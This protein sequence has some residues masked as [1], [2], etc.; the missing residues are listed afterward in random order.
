MKIHFVYDTV[1]LVKEKKSAPAGDGHIFTEE[2]E[3]SLCGKSHSE[4]GAKVAVRQNRIEGLMVCAACSEAWK[5]HP[6]SPWKKF[7]AAEA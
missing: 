4:I 6:E 3:T 7:V 2:A 5:C 1:R